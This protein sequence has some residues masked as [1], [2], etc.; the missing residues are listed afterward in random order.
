MNEKVFKYLAIFFLVIA[1]WSF[2][3]EPDYNGGS[4]DVNVQTLVPARDGLDLKAV[5]TL[6]KKA[7]TAEEFEK[8]LN[9]PVQGVNNLDLNGDGKVDYIN[10][11][12]YGDD[13]VKGFSLSTQ[14]VKG[15]TQ[16]LATIQVEKV[17]DKQA[18]VQVNGNE[19]I[20]GQNHSYRSHM[21]IG[22]MLMFAYIFRPHSYYRS[23]WHYGAY[24]SYYRP[25][26]S[27]PY[28]SYSN[29]TRG[30]YNRGAYTAGRGSGFSSS[31]KSPNAGKSASNIRAPLSR[32]TKSQ[33]SFQ[34]RS[35]NA[36][37]RSGGF[38]RSRSSS[39]RRGAS[40]RSGGFRSGK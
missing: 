19:Q 26:G 9:D 31:V 23:P 22:E 36:S 12:E 30:M 2:C 1:L 11:T 3:S 7:K 20:Y 35:A 40:S 37:R 39:T 5:G 34:T 28:S 8:L 6:L 15:E 24:P 38:G 21:G 16:E 17:S 10:V 4:Y 27:V 14:P 13:K 32:P 18:N 25:Y 33:K 29:R